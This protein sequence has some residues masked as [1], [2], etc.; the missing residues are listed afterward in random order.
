MPC[1]SRVRDA[2]SRRRDVAAP[3][4]KYGGETVIPKSVDIDRLKLDTG[5]V[6]MEISSRNATLLGLVITTAGMTLQPLGRLSFSL[7]KIQSQICV[8]G[9]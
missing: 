8:D 6:V 4:G 3:S 9:R 1:G 5:R 7:K 2:P